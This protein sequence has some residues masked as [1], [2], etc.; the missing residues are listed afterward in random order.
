MSDPSIAV[1]VPCYLERAHALDVLA[2]MPHSVA[3]IYCVDDACPEDTGGYIEREC[4][5]PR[6][7]VIRHS[8]NTG[9]G[10]AMV[11]GYR[12]ALADGC[13]IVVKIDGDGQMPPALIDQF[14]GP[15]LHG[16][17]DYTKGNR[18][19]RIEHIRDM[20]WAR[21]VGNAVFSFLSKLSSGYWHIFDPNNGFTAIHADVLRLLPLDRIHPGYF[22]ES[23][24]LFRLNILRAVVV[25]VPMP[26]R[27]GDETSHV[28]VWRELGV[29][30]TGHL[31]NLLKR[32]TYNYFLPDF[33]VAS[34]ECVL[35]P[36]LMLFGILFGGANW[37]EHVRAGEAATAGTVM[38][39]ALPL[40]LG[41]QLTLSALQFDM[42]NRP[43]VPLHKLISHES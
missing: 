10:G 1:V 2:A 43:T 27:Y 38:L 42:S 31:R 29:F 18:F 25:D 40:I 41:V 28:R 14:V 26:A 39:A 13:T 6:V 20:P 36:L 35:G 32:I 17:A 12:A 5:D 34:V 11:T 4:P 15:I 24:M 30:V 3:R 22:F 33:H 23:D 16:Y 8:H 37:I 19:Y 7:R 9:V 21:I